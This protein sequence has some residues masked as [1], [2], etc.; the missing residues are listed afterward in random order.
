V[1]KIAR[2]LCSDRHSAVGSKWAA[3]L[4]PRRANPCGTIAPVVVVRQV[5]ITFKASRGFRGR[6]NQHPAIILITEGHPIVD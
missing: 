6:S 1:W 2:C 4:E 5:T 3:Q